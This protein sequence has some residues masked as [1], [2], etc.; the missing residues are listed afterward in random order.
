MKRRRDRPTQAQDRAAATPTGRATR[1][2]QDHPAFGMW[3]DRSD[4]K[5]V[6]AWVRALRGCRLKGR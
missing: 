6:G 4:L 1:R 5:D 3:K 2:I